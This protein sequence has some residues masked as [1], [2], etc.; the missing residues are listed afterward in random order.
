M[1]RIP[2]GLLVPAIAWQYR[3][4]ERELSRINEFVPA[5]RGAVDVGVWWGP[6]SWWLARRVPRVE[7]FEPNADLVRRLT[8]ALP[9]NVNLHCVALSDRTGVSDLWVP[10]HGTGTEGRSSLEVGVMQKE[11][12]SRQVAISRLDDF[13]LKDIGFVKIDVEGHELAVLKGA[14]ELLKTDRPTVLVEVEPH[15]DQLGSLDDIIEFFDGH[16]YSGEYFHNGAWRPIGGLDRLRTAEMGARVAHHGYI[17]N[18]LLW[19][20]HYVH[21]FLFRPS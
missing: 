16:D 13:N 2:V 4:N 14:T 15:A 7:A 17:L 12:T 19:A 20:R 6:W 18:N 21:N 3:W 9:K 1:N 10:A 8:P 5:D 11:F